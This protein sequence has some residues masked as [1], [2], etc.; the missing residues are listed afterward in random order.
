MRPVE[1]LKEIAMS[2]AVKVVCGAAAMA[3]ALPVAASAQLTGQSRPDATPITNSPEPQTAYA[4]GAMPAQQLKPRPGIPM[5]APNTQAG[6][7]TFKVIGPAVEVKVPGQPAA[8]AFNPDANIVTT[9]PEQTRGTGE[10]LDAGI[11]TRL[12][13]P[14][15]QLPVGTLFK[16]RLAEEISTE[17]TATGTVFTALTTEPV[18][19]D[20]RVLLPVGSKVSGIVT[21]VHG[22]KR[23]SGPAS[24]HLRTLWVTL[25]DGTRYDLRGQVIDT[26]MYKEVRVDQEGTILGKDHAG[27]TAAT[28]ALTTGSGAAAGA[29]IAGVPG[30][31]IGAAAGAGV[32]TVVWLKQ[33]RQASLPAETTITFSLTQPLTVGGEPAGS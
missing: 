12:P 3:L 6:A 26:S 27:K 30:A 24:I 28:L 16:A 5:D 11:V 20:G 4:P 22:G 15:N 9:Y 13:G 1:F 32:S 17:N 29:V 8:A 14:S 23:S 25:P 7:P 19:R 2:I 21:D 18:L 31:L 33:Q 10:D